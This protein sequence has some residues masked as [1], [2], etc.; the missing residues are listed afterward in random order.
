MDTWPG[1]AGGAF[2]QYIPRLRVTKEYI[3]LYSSVIRN[4]GL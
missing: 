1:H 2:L 3:P 4:R